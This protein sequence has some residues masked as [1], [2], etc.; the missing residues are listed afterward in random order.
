MNVIVAIGGMD[1]EPWIENLRQRLPGRTVT[2]ADRAED[3][4]A[5]HYA[6]IWKHAP[7]GLSRFKNLRALFSVGAGV[8]NALRDPELPA[9]PLVRVVDEDLTNRMSEWVALHVLLHHRQQRMYEWQ[10]SEKIW[11][12][13]PRQPAAADVRVGMLGMGVLGRDA[14]RKL[15]LLGFDVA[16]WSR[17]GSAV[18]GVATYAGAGELDAFLARTDILVSLLPLTPQTRGII[19]ADLIR[20]LARDGRLGGPILLNAGRGGLQVEADILECLDEGSLRAATLDV[21]ETEPLP[22]NSPLWHHPA[23]TIT[24]HNSAISEPSAIVCGVARQIMALERGEVLR[25]VVDRAR[26]Y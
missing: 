23:V 21:F 26:G 7:G 13:D 24:P 2:H 18:E 9:A 5:A 15:S 1:P 25:N 12:D 10:Q 8:D 16:G 6:L 17:T 22:K 3:A 4:D 19:N 11:D 14:A 20:K